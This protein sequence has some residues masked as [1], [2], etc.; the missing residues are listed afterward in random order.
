MERD[1][2]PLLPPEQRIPFPFPFASLLSPTP[3]PSLLPRT[4]SLAAAHSPAAAVRAPP[5]QL[6]LCLWQRG[7][8]RTPVGERPTLGDTT[9]M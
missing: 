3:L 1:T 4:V 5:A 6:A 2:S 7:I 8:C 9:V